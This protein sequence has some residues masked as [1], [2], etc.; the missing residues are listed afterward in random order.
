MIIITIMI[1]LTII[2]SNVRLIIISLSHPISENRL[3]TEAPHPTS[4]WVKAF[5]S[6]QFTAMSHGSILKCLLNLPEPSLLCGNDKN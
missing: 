2:T 1:I 4:R 6:V 5:T 3:S